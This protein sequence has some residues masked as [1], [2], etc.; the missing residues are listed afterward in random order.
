MWSIVNRDGPIPNE[1]QMVRE[2]L[3]LPAIDLCDLHSRFQQ[4]ITF[5]ASK[6][7]ST[8]RIRLESFG[9]FVSTIRKAVF[10]HRCMVL[11]VVSRP[12]HRDNSRNVGV[13]GG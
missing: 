7:R 12:K 13:A 11:R 2:E 9:R 10:I 8:W 4:R 6:T 1:I 3:Q 5:K